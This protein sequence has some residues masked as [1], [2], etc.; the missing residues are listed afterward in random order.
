MVSEWIL[1]SC[2]CVPLLLGWAR[3]LLMHKSLSGK[4]QHSVVHRAW[5][6]TPSIAAGGVATSDEEC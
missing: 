6:S 5:D 1:R 4:H 2:F 3:K